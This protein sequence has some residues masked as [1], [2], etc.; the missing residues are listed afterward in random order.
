MV[1]CSNEE[2]P[3]SDDVASAFG[4]QIDFLDMLSSAFSTVVR[5]YFVILQ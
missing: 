4:T 1:L 5:A 2:N 3:S